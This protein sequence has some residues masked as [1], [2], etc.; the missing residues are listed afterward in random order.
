MMKEA[1]FQSICKY[2]LTEEDVEKFNNLT[3]NNY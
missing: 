3:D 1:K 2:N